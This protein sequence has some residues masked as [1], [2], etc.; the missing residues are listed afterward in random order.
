MDDLQKQPGIYIRIDQ[1]RSIYNEGRSTLT[2][3]IIIMAASGLIIGL[4]IY[5][6][7]NWLVLSRLALLTGLAQRISRGELDTGFTPG[8][9][10]DEIGI[11][12]RSMGMIVEYLSDVTRAAQKISTGSVSV[13]IT[14]RSEHDQLGLALGGMITRLQSLVSHIHSDTEQLSTAVGDLSRSSQESGQATSQIAITLQQ[15][16][17]GIAQESESIGRTAYSVDQMT[18]GIQGIVV[19]ARE[20]D[21]AVKKVSSLT[22]E[23]NQEIDQVARNAQSMDTESASAAA[24]AQNGA[25]TVK[26]TI[27]MMDRIREQV[28]ATSVLVQ[29]MGKHSRLIDSIVDTIHQIASQTNLL[30]LNAAIEAARASGKTSQV[31]QQLLQN[32]LVGAAFLVAEV[33]QRSRDSLTNN[34]LVTLA[35]VGKVDTLLI[36]DEDGVITQ[37]NDSS[38][39]GYRFSEDPREQSYEFRPLLRQRGGVVI[40]PIQPRSKD[41]LPFMWVGVSRSLQPGIIQ[42]G[43]PADIVR[44]NA[45]F[46]QG[47]AVVADEV[48]KLADQATQATKEVRGLIEMIQKTI[49][50]A[51]LAM[52]GSNREIEGG[53]QAAHR[54][55]EELEG[56]IDAAQQVREQAGQVSRA[57]IRMSGSAKS[58]VEAVDI[59]AAVVDSNLAATQ[60]MNQ[61]ATE[62]AQAMEN[63]ASIS[64]ENSASV[65]EVTA[66][67]GE[68]AQQAREVVAAV[69]L[70]QEMAEG[71][72]VSMQ[73]YH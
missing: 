36:T 46:A 18:R 10:K 7:F 55:G 72:R 50:D 65:E 37:C 14:P 1:P 31:T 52:D 3:L 47:F 2:Y 53:V 24:A 32:Q 40:Q 59:V 38:L 17:T 66:N 44:R 60:S 62:V 11:L 67:T 58:L 5:V 41:G 9:S 45:T 23:M 73:D 63:I 13:K 20:Q 25:S 48:R 4:V 69:D 16:S 22:M 29:E 27:E 57:T 61:S 71:L 35:N 39:I 6:A 70:L 8:A 30:A 49:S 68:M 12:E 51:K 19:G 28:G 43:M 64:E 42:A 34:D 56:L 15:I 26:Q 33:D 54:A 21:Q